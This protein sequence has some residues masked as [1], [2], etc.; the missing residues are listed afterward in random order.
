MKPKLPRTLFWTDKTS[1][2][3]F[4]CEPINERLFDFYLELKN[5]RW[6]FGPDN[7]VLL[8]FNEIYYQ[9]TKIEY[10]NNLDFNM[11]E[12]TQEIEA[13]TGKEHSIIFVFKIFFA[14]LLLRQNNSNVARLFQDHVF[15]RYKST[16]DERT[17]SAMDS[18]IKE[19]KKYQVDFRP[20]PCRVNDLKVEELQW[21]EITNK[22]DPSSIKE[23]LN[24]WPHKEEKLKVLHLIESEYKRKSRR[25]VK[26]ENVMN[27]FRVTGDFFSNLYSELGNDDGTAANIEEYM[28]RYT[29]TD[30]DIDEIF[31]SPV[32]KPIGIGENSDKIDKR[33][34]PEDFKTP[35]AEQLMQKL[36]DAGLLTSNWQ[37]VNLSIAERGYLAADISSRLNI[38]Y[39]WK[40]MG[41]LWDE[42]PGTLRKG[43]NNAIN[44]KKT[45][46]L[47]EKLK[48]ILG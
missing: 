13:K 41:E 14:F 20:T 10:E 11:D 1:M 12:Y 44:Q 31:A 39:K 40:V 42:N 46:T 33:T 15:N 38:N 26:I 9:L 23:V 6:H 21:D 16:W 45:G 35:E 18:I 22:F 47:I 30:K 34:L 48:N 19:G 27:Y 28:E 24:L 17:N 2:E 43:K 25:P 7:S 36:V 5:T 37:P 3:E 8:L 4:L 32:D 29:A